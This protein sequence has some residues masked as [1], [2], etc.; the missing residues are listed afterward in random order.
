MKLSETDKDGFLEQIQ[1]CEKQINQNIK[2]L[3]LITTQEAAEIR[4]T[5]RQAILSLIER[6]RL[7]AVYLESFNRT[8]VYKDQVKKFSPNR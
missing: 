1:D 5:T 6:E 4:G 8:Y 3:G 2:L 7:D